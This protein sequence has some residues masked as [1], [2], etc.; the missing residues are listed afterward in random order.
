MSLLAIVVLVFLAWRFRR[1]SFP[2]LGP[3]LAGCMIAF[4]LGACTGF[5]CWSD[6]HTS[7]EKL[8]EH[9]GSYAIRIEGDPVETSN[10]SYSQASLQAD[11]CS[12][13]V[14]VMWRE[15]EDALPVG[16]QARCKGKLVRL[17]TSDKTRSLHRSLVAVR[18]T[19]SKI[20]EVSWAPTLQG[21]FGRVRQPCIER[22][23]AIGG[24]GA[25]ILRGI[26]LGDRS[27]VRGTELEDAFRATGLAHMLAVSGTHLTVVALLVTWAMQWLGANRRRTIAV[28]VATA[29]AY[30]V[31]TA[32]QPS[33]FRACIMAAVAATAW[34]AGRRANSIAALVLAVGGLLVLDPSNAFAVGFQLSALGVAGL[35]LFMPLASWWMERLLPMRLE[36]VGQPL[37]LTLVAQAATAPVAVPAFAMLSLVGPFANLI[38]APV[39]AFLLGGGLV[40]L[41]LLLV[42]PPVG[43]ALLVAM[44]MLADM[45]ARVVTVLFHLPVVAAPVFASQPVALAAGALA[46]VGLWILWPLPNRHAVRLISGAVLGG[47]ALLVALLPV[48]GGANLVVM[49]VGQGDAILLSDGHRQV[50]VDTGP[51]DTDLRAALGRQGVRHL[52]AV[53]LTHLDDDHCAALGALQSLVRVDCVIVASGLIEAAERDEK[54]A[55]VVDTARELCDREGIVEVEAGDEIRVSDRM[56]LSVVWPRERVEE[57]ANENSVCLLLGFDADRDE[58]PDHTVLLTGDAEHE[59]LAAMVDAGLGDIDVLKVGHHGSAESVDEKVLR[60]LKPELALISVGAGNSYGHPKKGTLA[61]LEEAGSR[62][63]RTDEDGDINLTFDKRGTVVRCTGK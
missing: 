14:R 60:V 59:E 56:K 45:L 37:A 22:L 28:L 57:S 26:L 36:P 38:V 30:L 39:I 24:D 53:V 61:L 41:L 55:E 17:E 31:F 10:G 2:R 46:A 49:E 13:R 54:A 5:F 19:P 25:A 43:G 42:L 52:D 48:A 27:A 3:L 18:F 33:A 58:A 12:A 6:L 34:F 32:L 23:A 62:I 63:Y 7:A 9:D 8:V 50:L 21:L 4:G 44:S 11:G 51:R 35:C 47:L 16:A 1:H 20:E 29:I 40:S 15:A